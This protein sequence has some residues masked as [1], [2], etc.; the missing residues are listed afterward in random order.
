MFLRPIG[1]AA[2]AVGC[3]LPGAQSHTDLDA[4][5]SSSSVD[6]SLESETSAN[7]PQYRDRVV[8][9]P[10]GGQH[11]DLQR[12]RAATLPYACHDGPD[13]RFSTSTAT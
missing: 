8:E 7:T 12:Q 10:T 9:H 1:C 2:L 13:Y 5:P 11:S 3:G 6:A 4:G